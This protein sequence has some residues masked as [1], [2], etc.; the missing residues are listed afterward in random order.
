MA[1]TETRRLKNAT[2]T[3][4]YPFGKGVKLPP[5][6]QDVLGGKGHGLAQMA[7]LE[8][9]VPPGFIITTR[10]C[11]SFLS[12]NRSFPGGLQEEI[13]AAL[14]VLEAQMDAKLGNIQKPLLVS[15]RSGAPI[16]MPGMMDTVL[17]LGLNDK[18]VE[19]FAKQT[20][21][22][23]L[24]Y[25]SYR[26]FLSMY[27][28]IV[29]GLSRREFEEEH[30]KLLE[31]SQ[32][33]S[34][35]V[36]ALKALCERYKELYHEQ[37]GSPFPQDPKVQLKEAISSVFESWHSERATLYR[38]IHA[39]PHDLGT[40]VNVQAMVFGNK[41]DKSA[42]GV[43]FT[44]DPATGERQF[45]GEFLVNAQGEE[46]VAGIRTPQ[47]IN[48]HQKRKT[49]ATLASLEELMPETYGELEKVVEILEQHYRDMQDLEF[50][51]DDGRLFM[52]Q[53]RT[54]KRT[55]WA[56]VRIALDMWEE[57]LID[58]ITALKRVDPNQLVQLLAPIF[59][60]KAKDK[61]AK[62]RVA[63]GLNA[64]PGAASGKVAL[65][66]QRAT[67]WQEIGQKCILVREETNP[68]DFPGMAA[69]EGILTARGGA[70]SHAA[71]VARGMGKPC[72]AGCGELSLDLRA[73]TI[74][75]GGL[76]IH[77]GDPISIDGT[78]GEVFFCA[79]ETSPSEIVQV[80]Q[81][82]ERRPEDS[83][84]FKYYNK[85]MQLA[86]KH[87]TMRVRSNA[88]TGQDAL[89]AQAFGAEGIGLCR[90][91]HMFLEESR[92]LDV[93]CFLFSTN[94][95]QTEQALE[96]LLDYQR[97]DFQ[98]LFEAAAG[99]PVTI[100]LLDPPLHE[101][102]PHGRSGWTNLAKQL[103][104]PV[105][106]LREIENTLHEH[107]PMLGFRGCRLGIA[108]P[109][110]T[111]MQ[112]QAMLEAAL[113]VEKAGGSVDLEIMVPLIALESEYI[114]QKKL[115]DAT[116]EEVFA[117]AKRRVKYSVGTMIEL[118]RAAIIADRIAENADFFSFGTNDLTQT[119]LGISRD[120]SNRFLPLYIQ[121]VPNPSAPESTYRLLT[122]DPFQ[123]LDRDGVGALMQWAVDR[124]RKTRP[125]LKCGI[126]GEHGGDP[127]SVQLCQE[128]GINYVSC[129]PY[130]VPIARLAAA[131][132]A[133]ETQDEEDVSV[134]PR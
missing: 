38:Q 91:E 66:S 96:N 53:T 36:D 43:G 105:K 115:I 60:T 10:A 6:G 18:T 42:T 92:L 55:G 109:K 11:N 79:L 84:V 98:N 63:K 44:R 51:I 80:L 30:Q 110:L 82:K 120:D 133:V 72:V 48:A 128:L 130:R 119:T 76:T 83:L 104:V 3:Y 2:T 95:Q 14:A 116:A 125:D 67:E 132:A 47:P 85:L 112:V 117:K 81:T 17:N 93:R 107:N 58:E 57:G 22:P 23:R 37:V 118:P 25:D 122:H 52:L 70:T 99:S 35:N 127:R 101:F 102:L 86:D 29:A 32:G 94:D 50:T 124:G 78:T 111:K 123:V 9:P 64:G 46:V 89:V 16:S 26:R 61:A 59:D 7:S 20:G 28:D 56:A 88:D 90:T 113:D 121:G 31:A 54:G 13:D 12:H 27:S 69:S 103:Q 131:Q 74:S 34:L 41:N 108:N 73:G 49:D 129:S 45:Y 21:N 77:E 126:C 100:R 40:A 114:H 39:I 134:V 68:D 19:G 8:L 15:V 71:V 1:S 65:T 106:H 75:A 97:S 62:S 33:D 24:A 4:V 5:L 87:R